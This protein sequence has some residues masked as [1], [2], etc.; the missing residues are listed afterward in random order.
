MPIQNAQVTLRPPPLRAAQTKINQSA[1][2]PAPTKGLDI[3]TPLVAQD[4]LIALVLNNW[5]CRKWGP[6]LREGYLRWTSNIGGVGIDSSVKTLMSY[7]PPSGTR[8]LF[9]SAVNGSI[10]DVTLQTNEAT[11]PTA[12]N[13]IA[14]QTN[15]GEHAYVNFTTSAGTYLVLTAEGSGVHTYDDSG[16][17]VNRTASLTGYGTIPQN[18][19]FVTVWKN[20]L[21]FIRKNSTQAYYLPVDSI[22]GALALFDFGPLFV[23]GGSLAIIATWTGDSGDGIDDRMVVVSTEGDVLVYAGTDPSSITTFGL[24]GRWYVGKTPAGRRLA[25]KYGGDLAIITENGLEF[26]SRLVNARGLLDP[27]V[28]RTQPSYRFNDSLGRTVEATRDE[29]FWAI[30]HLPSK[31][32]VIICTPDNTTSDGTQFVYSSIT[33]AWS[34]FLRM[35]MQCMEVFDGDLY[36]GTTNGKVMRAFAADTDDE[37]SNGTIGTDVQGDLQTAFVSDTQDPSAIKV[38]QLIRPMFQA[39]S[40]PSV[41]AQINTEWTDSGT[42]GNLS[43]TGIGSSL[44]DVATWD[45]SVWN[46]ELNTYISWLGATGLGAYFSLRLSVLGPPGTTFVGWTLIYEKGIDSYG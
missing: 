46:A 23:N 41:A 45:S 10:Y 34:I 37:L 2:F 32:S 19:D 6:E 22:T 26:I 7:S 12:S 13:T 25:S 27:D 18:F 14:S 39:P 15:P 30:A 31:S 29:K 8:V 4:P 38:P 21:W 1:T 24:I 33:P 20:R 28:N 17:W 43:F 5:W 36:F 44:W 42:P 9:A 11:A 3:A 35:P 40:A 16:G